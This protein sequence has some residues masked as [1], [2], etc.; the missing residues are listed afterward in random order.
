MGSRARAQSV[1]RRWSG[2]VVRGR[3]NIF[4]ITLNTWKNWRTSVD[5]QLGLLRE[6]D[7]ILVTEQRIENNS[8]H[9][10]ERLLADLGA[11]VTM[12]PT[13]SAGSD[14]ALHA[15]L[16]TGREGGTPKSSGH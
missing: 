9:E 11:D 10:G 1:E 12:S 3:E 15:G 7:E 8:D 2:K 14:S 5:H 16:P 4:E 13:T 6:G